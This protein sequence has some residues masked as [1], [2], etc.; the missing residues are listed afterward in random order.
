MATKQQR[1]PDAYFALFAEKA[2]EL[3]NL[4]MAGIAFVQFVPGA[5]HSLTLLLY[6]VFVYLTLHAIAFLLMKGG[7]GT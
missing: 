4:A 5:P 6:G 7:E 3:A 2:M 1:S